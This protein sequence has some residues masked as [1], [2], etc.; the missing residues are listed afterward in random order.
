[1][2]RL[3]REAEELRLKAEE[4]KMLAIFGFKEPESKRSRRGS[5]S[6]VGLKEAIDDHSQPQDA[7][8]SEL[9]DDAR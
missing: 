4:E 7:P 9:E 8:Q 5:E 2:A 3:E 6:E 1:M